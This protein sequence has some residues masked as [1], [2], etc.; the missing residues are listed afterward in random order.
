MHALL[1]T[2]ITIMTRCY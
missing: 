2:I 1:S